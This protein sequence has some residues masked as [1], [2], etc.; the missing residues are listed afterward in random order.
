MLTLTWSTFV[1]GTYQLQYKSGLT[2]TSW[3]N[4]GNPITGTS[5]SATTSHIIGTDR[6]R[7]YRV[8]LLQ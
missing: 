8:V 6:Q 3:T 2:Q 4:S 1:G 7:F 5:T